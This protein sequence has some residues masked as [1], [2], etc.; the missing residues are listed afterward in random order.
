[1]KT[2]FVM[3][4]TVLAVGAPVGAETFHPDLHCGVLEQRLQLYGLFGAGFA[5]RARAEV[6]SGRPAT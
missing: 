5:H 3:A 2:K 6:R 4:A 1:M